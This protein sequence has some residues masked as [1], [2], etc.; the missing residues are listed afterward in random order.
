MRTVKPVP[1]LPQTAPPS[2]LTTECTIDKPPT[3]LSKD[4]L[5]KAWDSQTMNVGDCNNKNAALRDWANKVIKELV[6]TINGGS[7]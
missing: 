3:D 7:K 2:N 4:S 6:N 5:V 1:N